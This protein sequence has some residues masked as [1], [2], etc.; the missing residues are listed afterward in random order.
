MKKLPIG[1]YW[2]RFNPPHK[3]HLGLIRR[4]HHRYRLIVAIGSAEHH[5]ERRNPFGGRERK[6]MIESYLKE[7]GI[8][9]ERVATLEDGDSETWSV[10]SLIRKSK[11]DAVI[12]SSERRGGLDAA[13]TRAG[14]R[15]V[16]FKRTGNVSS[17]L[18]RHII[19]TDDPE[20]SNLTGRSVAK[21]IEE[22]GGVERIRRLYARSTTP[23]AR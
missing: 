18:I 19:A 3:G 16:R 5:H 6:A 11:P 15:V 10:E 20:W 9:D 8:D 23:T 21:L 2:G 4:F 22:I 14:V 17:T 13:L 7:A 1:V 12:L